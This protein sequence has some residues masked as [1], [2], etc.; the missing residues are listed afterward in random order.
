MTKF[1]KNIHF[2]R[3]L[4]I[5]FRRK[6]IYSVCAR[7]NTLVTTVA[8]N[9]KEDIVMNEKFVLDMLKTYFETELANEMWF[10]EDR[11]RILLQDG[12]IAEITVTK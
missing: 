12:T 9:T 8:N 2:F 5:D 11:I 4:H 7:S 3:F 10:E 6:W 1:D